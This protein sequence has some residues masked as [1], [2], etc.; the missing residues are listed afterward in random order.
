MFQT[1]YYTNSIRPS[2]P[3]ATCLQTPLP[4]ILLN[5]YVTA[6]TTIE[7]L[8]IMKIARKMNMMIIIDN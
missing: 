7:I 1:T 2:G 3:G 8:M 5:G 4:N 6:D